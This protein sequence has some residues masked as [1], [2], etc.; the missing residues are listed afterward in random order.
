MG[1]CGNCT[2]CKCNANESLLDILSFT[3]QDLGVEYLEGASDVEVV[4]TADRKIRML[5]QLCVAAGMDE[6]VLKAA[7]NG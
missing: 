3:L 7:L 1:N 6:K 5:Y 4:D 2:D